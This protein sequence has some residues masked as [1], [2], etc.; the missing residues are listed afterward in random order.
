MNGKKRIFS[1][2]QN[3]MKWNCDTFC[4][5]KWKN[6]TFPFCI[7][8]FFTNRVPVVLLLCFYFLEQYITLLVQSSTS[9]PS[10]LLRNR[11]GRYDGSTRYE[12][13]QA[14][15]YIH[16][17]SFSANTLITYAAHWIIEKWCEFLKPSICRVLKTDTPPHAVLRMRS[18]VW[19]L[20]TLNIPQWW[21]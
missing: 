3:R 7:L 13:F 17:F 4:A 15:F 14:Y 6:C 11:G 20:S 21:L 12:I 5:G 16:G 1:L 8:K 19:P 2:S 10:I 18:V 9:S